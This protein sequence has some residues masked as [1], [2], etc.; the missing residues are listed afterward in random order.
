MPL[1]RNI[2]FALRDAWSHFRFRYSSVDAVAVHTLPC[3]HADYDAMLSLFHIEDIIAMILLRAA[4]FIRARH[5]LSLQIGG[6]DAWLLRYA[7]HKDTPKK[8][9][10][11]LFHDETHFTSLA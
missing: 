2:F 11:S 1:L 5:L 6:R 3:R 10:P 8:I 9:L 4:P 7:G